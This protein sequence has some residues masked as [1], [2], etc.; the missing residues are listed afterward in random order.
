MNLWMQICFVCSAISDSSSS[1]VRQQKHYN[2]P[3]RETSST[4]TQVPGRGPLFCTSLDSQQCCFASCSM[5][6]S[7]SSSRGAPWTTQSSCSGSRPTGTGQQVSSCCCGHA[8]CSSLALARIG[9]A[10]S[11]F[12]LVPQAT[13]RVTASGTAACAGSVTGVQHLSCAVTCVP[14]CM[15]CC[16]CAVAGGQTI[17]DYDPVARRAQCK[18]GGLKG[19]SDAATPAA[20]AAAAGARW[21]EGRHS[22]SL[23]AQQRSW[24]GVG[25]GRFGT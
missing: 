6:M 3:Q 22:S 20:R 13:S 5:L 8:W 12:A 2:S 25:V 19:G 17:D 18:T 21:K 11:M 7:P 15:A 4:W 14:G 10:T 9:R 16:D 23:Q 1:T 24:A